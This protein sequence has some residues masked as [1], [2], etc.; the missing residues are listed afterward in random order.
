MVEKSLNGSNLDMKLLNKYKKLNNF[1]KA[2]LWFTV[3][4]AMT[5]AGVL[6]CTPFYTR[7][8]TSEQYGEYAVWH[9]WNGI[10]AA[11]TTLSLYNSGFTVGMTKYEKDRDRYTS[12]MMGL[13]TILSG[14]ALLIYSSVIS[15]N[16]ISICPAY[17]Y[18]MLLEIM[19]MSFFYFWSSYERYQYRY[20]RLLIITVA[21]SFLIIL[22]TTVIPC[23]ASQEKRLD[24]RIYSEVVVWILIGS[25]CFWSIMKRSR[26][27]FNR[28]YWKYAVFKNVPLIPHY[29]SATILNQSDRIMIGKIYGNTEVAYYNLAYMIS[30]MMLVVTSAIKNSFD[31]FFYQNIKKR[32]ILGIA[33]KINVLFIIV[34]C[35]CN[36]CTAIGPEII[37]IFAPSNYYEARFVIPPLAAS[38]FFIF[39]YNIFSCVEFYYGNS[40]IIMFISCFGAV[41]NV[42]LNWFLIPVWGYIAAG[43]TTLISYI[44]FACG[45]LIVSTYVAKRRGIGHIY[46]IKFILTSF[47]IMLATMALYCLTYEWRVVSY[48]SLL[49]FLIIIFSKRNALMDILHT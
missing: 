42:M 34:I 35:L 33:G 2:A 46:D 6:I 15:G 29:L 44:L 48:F 17:V 13:T 31:P 43:Y 9:S 11:F 22:G 19:F 20:V 36:I 30:S 3:C 49:L 5:R 12:S 4:N 45:H 8:L 47:M 40:K 27:I 1:I 26:R 37:K 10:I 32:N 38:I 21:E 39:A 7:I 16:V 23:F 28:Q 24:V 41:F 14:I 25:Y 18:A